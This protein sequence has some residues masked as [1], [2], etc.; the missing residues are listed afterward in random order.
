[1]NLDATDPCC[2]LEVSP[3]RD[4][5]DS[6]LD[7]S[8]PADRES[9]RSAVLGEHHDVG[10][11]LEPRERLK[12]TRGFNRTEERTRGFRCNS[13]YYNDLSRS[14]SSFRGRFERAVRPARS[15]LGDYSAQSLHAIK[16][17]ERS[18]SGLNWRSV[19]LRFLL[20]PESAGAIRLD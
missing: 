10:L 14:V 7:R 15:Y 6:T 2:F 16:S 8:M 20:T 13:L 1:M 11:Q 18:D 9:T 4:S 17:I 5:S 3:C 12:I 19:T